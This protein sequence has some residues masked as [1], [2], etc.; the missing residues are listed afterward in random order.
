[1]NKLIEEY[2]KYQRSQI[3]EMADWHEG[4]DMTGVSVSDADKAAGSPKA[5]D[6]I[7]RNAKNHADRWLVAASYFA[8][9]FTAVAARSTGEPEA[10]LVN[11]REFTKSGQ[12]RNCVQASLEPR[13]PTILTQFHPDVDKRELISVT[14]LY[15]HPL[16][17]DVVARSDLVG[18]FDTAEELIASLE[19]KDVVAVPKSSIEWLAR[20]RE[21]PMAYSYVAEEAIQMAVNALAA[22]P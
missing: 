14:P 16:P 2:K 20:R 19:D 17:A 11:Y 12:P 6:K 22:K 18:P 10:Y 7:A 1:M 4:F 21:E 8:D 9:N 5:G 3:A 15:A 13:E